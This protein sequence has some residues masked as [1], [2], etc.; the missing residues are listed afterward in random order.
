M[1]VAIAMLAMLKLMDVSAFAKSFSKYDLLTKRWAAYGCLYPFLEI[2]IALGFLAKSMAI[3]TEWL[4]LFVGMLDM[5]SVYKAVVVDKLALNCACT[6]VSRRVGFGSQ[7]ILCYAIRIY[8]LMANV[9]ALH[10]AM[11]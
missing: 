4:A 1:G 8:G 10:D 11:N 5:A 2:F 6:T 9:D 3:L 7:V